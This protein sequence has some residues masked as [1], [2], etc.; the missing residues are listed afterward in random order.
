MGKHQL[1]KEVMGMSMSDS[2]KGHLN[3]AAKLRAYW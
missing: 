1:P 2:A 3:G